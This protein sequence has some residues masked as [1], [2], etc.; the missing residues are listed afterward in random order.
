MFRSAAIV[1]QGLRRGLLTNYAVRT[2][3]APMSFVA[4]SSAAGRHTLETRKVLQDR[5]QHSTSPAGPQKAAAD[6]VANAIAAE[7]SGCLGPMNT[8]VREM[9]SWRLRPYAS[10]G[11]QGALP[12]ATL[13][14]GFSKV[15]LSILVLPWKI[16]PATLVIGPMV[17]G[18]P[19]IY[20]LMFTNS[21]RHTTASAFTVLLY[22]V[23]SFLPIPCFENL[24]SE[25]YFL[26]FALFST[27]FMYLFFPEVV[28]NDFMF[29]HYLAL[30]M[31]P[32]IPL[33]FTYM[34]L[35]ATRSYLML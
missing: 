32:L 5:I 21:S 1:R 4:A 18:L 30:F 24:F 23:I 20:R 17:W 31:I 35:F 7:K 26:G 6:L 19:A 15:G 22:F 29:M 34:P 11:T 12:V 10:A 8:S 25:L 3:L 33:A 13:S 27:F 16:L 14:T 2:G 28:L 9:S